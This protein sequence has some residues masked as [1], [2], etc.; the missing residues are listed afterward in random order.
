MKSHPEG[1]LRTRDL[2]MPPPTACRGPECYMSGK[3][4]GPRLKGEQWG[5]GAKSPWKLQMCPLGW[6][7]PRAPMGFQEKKESSTI[8]RKIVMIKHPEAQRGDASTSVLTVRHDSR[9][10]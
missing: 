1:K 6:S 2:T 5:P 8:G 10:Q 3:S 7:C 4:S 9:D